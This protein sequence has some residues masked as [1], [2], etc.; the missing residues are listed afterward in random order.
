ME[1]QR[2]SDV[3]GTE[4][5]KTPEESLGRTAHFLSLR[6]LCGYWV[7]EGVDFCW[8]LRRQKKGQRRFWFRI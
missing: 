3:Q 2:I 7:E 4:Q 6:Y 8:K 5:G 1:A